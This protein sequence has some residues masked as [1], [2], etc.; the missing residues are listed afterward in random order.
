MDELLSNAFTH[1]NLGDEAKRISVKM[2]FDADKFVLSVKDEGEGFDGESYLKRIREEQLSIP[3]K[4]GLFIVDLL[5]DE[6]RFNQRG[7]EV[8]AVLY[9]EHGIGSE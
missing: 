4:R 8:T 2:A 1:G 7:N 3:E 6:L 9:R 5:M